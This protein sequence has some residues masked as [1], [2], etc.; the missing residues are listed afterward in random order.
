M[1]IWFLGE[2]DWSA[3]RHLQ[4]VVLSGYSARMS[5]SVP[6][7][8]GKPNVLPDWLT[9]HP[10]REPANPLTLR[11]ASPEGKA[12]LIK[13]FEMVLPRVLEMV[14]EGY[15]LNSA[16]KEIPVKVDAGAF[17]RWLRKRPEY[18]M[19]KEAKE[20]RTEAWAGEIIRHSLGEDE[21]GSASVNDTAR[22]RLIVDTYKWLMSADNRK[23]YGDT[24]TIEMNTSISITA[25]LAQAQGRVIEAQLVDDDVD[26][27]PSSGYKQLSAPVIDTEYEDDE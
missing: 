25:A 11:G 15:T 19:Y 6:D 26:L 27:L 20:V 7:W 2:S 14:C 22:S 16:L 4:A 10:P 3:G 8:L 5:A 18:E 24:K 21:D 9:V 12:L 23:Q 13:Q 1:V 17:I